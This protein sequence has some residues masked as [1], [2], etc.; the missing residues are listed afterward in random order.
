VDSRSRAKKPLGIALRLARKLRMTA[1]EYTGVYDENVGWGKTGDVTYEVDVPLEEAVAEYFSDLSTPCRVI[2]EDAGVVDYGLEPKY[3]FMIDPL[4]GSRNARRG[5]P[6]HCSS[7]AVYEA[8]ATELSE[9]VSSVIERHDLREEYVAV[10][11]GGATLNDRKI[12]PSGKTV[13]NDAVLALGCHFAPAVGMYAKLSSRLGREVKSH[14]RNITVKSYGSTALEL[15]LLASGKVDM[16]L[17]IRASTRYRAAPK[18]YD[19]AAGLL[20]CS[21]AG[22]IVEY[23]GH[24]LPERLPLDPTVRVQ[25]AGAGNMRLF[26]ILRNSLR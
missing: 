25:V 22:A 11:G 19:I 21:E 3:V 1:G 16:L 23:G 15:A 6:L 14:E 26:N 8:G 13:L 9:A 20:L 2:T 24:T 18:T 17:D 7:I 10:R 12:K 5:L 4:D